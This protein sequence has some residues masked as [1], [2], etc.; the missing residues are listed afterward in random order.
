MGKIRDFM[1][2][3]HRSKSG[4]A[5]LLLALGTPMLIGGT[6]LAVDTAQWYLWKRELQFAVDQSAIAAAWAKSEAPTGTTYVSRGTQEYENNLS[7]VTDFDSGPTITLEDYDGGTDNS[8]QV[9]ASATGSLP[10]SSFLTG[11][12]ATVSARAVAI[13]EPGQV[14]N[15]CML[16]LDPTAA[17]ALFLN[18]TVNVTATCGVGAIS[19]S[20]SAVTKVGE[21]GNVDVGFVITGGEIVD[22]HGHFDEETTV[23]NSRDVSDPYDDLTPPDNPTPRSLSCANGPDDAYT[24]DESVLIETIYAYFKGK[25]KNQLTEISWPDGRSADSS[26]SFT[27][28][29]EFGS[30]PVNSI[31][32][33][34]PVF[35]EISGGGNDKIWES[36][37]TTTT[38]TYSDVEAPD[39][40]NGAAL[41]GTYSDFDVK[42]DTV[43]TSGIYVIDGGTLSVNANTALSGAGVMFVLKNGASIQ[44]AGSARIAL[45]AMDEFQLLAAGVPADD[46][47]ALLGM[48][49]FED[50]DS[51]GSSQSQITGSSRAVFDGIIY[52]PNSDLKIAGTPKGNSQCMVIA[53]KT[54]QFAGT[55]DVS[56]LCPTGANPKGV[57]SETKNR[58]LLV[59]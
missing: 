47:D 49:I 53:T 21:S 51:P 27:D 5:T 4:N 18:G 9:V 25:N 45:S 28:D 50:P 23:E 54:L 7:L 34:D 59:G 31:T 41:P 44:I 24:A 46:V 33:D 19:N 14:F 29:K 43:M 52:L 8:V 10:F 39:S 26:S 6:G 42:C 12:G 22:E 57:V 48:L 17:E 13:F 1:R 35:T 40:G 38:K 20:S 56:S 16:A 30:L 58:V 2:K 15:P 55:T 32:V 36:A 3:L 37:T 11:E